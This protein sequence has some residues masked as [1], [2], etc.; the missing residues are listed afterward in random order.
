MDVHIWRFIPQSSRLIADDLRRLGVI[1]LAVVEE[2]PTT[3]FEFFITMARGR[4][5]DPN[6]DR[7]ATLTRIAAETSITAVP[8]RDLTPGD[9][10]TGCEMEVS[11]IERLLLLTKRRLMAGIRARG[12][13]RRSLR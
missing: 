10:G 8:H 9:P 13:G 5:L 2:F 12:L 7:V 4:G 3:N 1:E 11:E 6:P